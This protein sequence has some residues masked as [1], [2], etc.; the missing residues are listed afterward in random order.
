VR[1]TPYGAGSCR[2]R[3]FLY[4]FNADEKVLTDIERQAELRKLV[5]GADA[6]FLDAKVVSKLLELG[7]DSVR[8]LLDSIGQPEPGLHAL[9]RAGSIRWCCR[10]S[11]PPGLKRRGPGRSGLALLRRRLL[12]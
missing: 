9:A 1:P 10:H 11:S 8:E 4:V 5:D 6:V 12:E 7:D 2:R 3:P